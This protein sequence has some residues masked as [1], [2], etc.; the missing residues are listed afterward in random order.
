MRHWAREI[1][2]D[3]VITYGLSKVNP[4]LVQVGQKRSH[5][6]DWFW[7]PVRRL[8][9]SPSLLV[10]RSGES[11]LADGDG[12]VTAERNSRICKRPKKSRIE[13]AGNIPAL[14][15]AL[16]CVTPWLLTVYPHTSGACCWPPV[17]P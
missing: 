10:S 1:T 3:F 11:S 2:L 17:S 14:P 8:G 5:G 4:G 12:P 7:P 6:P 9:R 16:I 15:C 13:R